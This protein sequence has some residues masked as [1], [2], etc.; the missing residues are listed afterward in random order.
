MPRYAADTDVTPEK[1]RQ[2]IERT[3]K[4]YA[5]DEYGFAERADVAAILFRYK[6][7]R[8]RFLVA[9]PT[10]A[11]V[12]RYPGGRSRDYRQYPAAKAQLERQRWRVLLLTIKAR[13]EAVE[14]GQETAEDAFLAYTVL[15]SGDTVSEWLQPQIDDA[16]ATGQMPGLLLGLPDGRR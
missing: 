7:R 1:T 2:E 8:V 9:R 15:P 4:R 16:Y 3:V 12:A 14:A 5:A 11:D 6:G 10:D 13:L